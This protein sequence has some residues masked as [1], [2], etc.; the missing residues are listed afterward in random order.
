MS[1]A[2][3]P[4]ILQI[5]VT[6]VLR[7]TAAKELLAKR[8]PELAK[9]FQTQHS[10]Q[11]QTGTQQGDPLGTVLSFRLDGSCTTPPPQ[12]HGYLLVYSRLGIS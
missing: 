12:I 3:Q 1:K 5:N 4:E 8:R 9:Y 10:I 11:S 7:R 6:N 2:P